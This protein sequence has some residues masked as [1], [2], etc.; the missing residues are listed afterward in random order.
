MIL[1]LAFTSILLLK[2]LLLGSSSENYYLIMMIAALGFAFGIYLMDY[3]LNRDF[4]NNDL[5]E[6]NEYH[7]PNTKILMKTVTRNKLGIFLIFVVVMVGIVLPRLMNVS[8]NIPFLNMIIFLAISTLIAV[9]FSVLLSFITDG[10][11]E[12]TLKDGTI[13]TVQWSSREIIDS[14]D[15][16]GTEVRSDSLMIE[17]KYGNEFR[18]FVNEPEDLEDAITAHKI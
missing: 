2:K 16:E 5:Y 12:T 17:T 11:A 3:T 15:I 10:F 4:Y 8:E 6:A 18:I 9:L 14:S 13:K 7:I 1:V